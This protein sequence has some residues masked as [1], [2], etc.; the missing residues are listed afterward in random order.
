MKM[1]INIGLYYLDCYPI[2]ILAI[3]NQ[4]SLWG[5]FFGLKLQQT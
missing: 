1:I 3:H 2:D 5:I 4:S